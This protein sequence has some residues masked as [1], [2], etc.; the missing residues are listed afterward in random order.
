[1]TEKLHDL[2][3]FI[4]KND[5]GLTAGKARSLASYFTDVSEFLGITEEALANVRGIS[6]RRAIRL[7]DEEISNIMRIIE[8]DYLDANVSIPE[9]FLGAISRAFTKRQMDMI[10][11]LDLSRLSPN[12]LLIKALNIHTPEELVKINV[13]MVV[14]RS[15]VTSMGFFVENLL[16]ASSDSIEKGPKGSGWDLVKEKSGDTHWIQVKSGPNDM[17]KDQ[18]VYWSQKITE[19]ISE[20]DCA[21][22]GITYGKSTSETVTLGLMK[23]LLPDWE[24]KTLIG[25]ELW[26]FVSDDPT[27]HTKLFDT[28]RSSA[29]QVLQQRSICEEI[30]NCV[31]RIIDEFT[32]TYG[33]GE[34][35]VSKYIESIF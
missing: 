31:E 24:M 34:E 4:L 17:D 29:Q 21:Y 2:L 33:G 27:Y 22:I 28:L 14:T 23:Q 20:G 13:Y 9:N 8:L 19:K 1:M 30:D 35:G 26:D 15:I 10:M 11:N 25:R 32:I 18:I 7:T 6:G 3:A 12:P 5:A 16:L